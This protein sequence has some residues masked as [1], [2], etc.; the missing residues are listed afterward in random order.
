MKFKDRSN[1]ILFGGSFNPI[2]LGH[3][4]LVRAVAALPGVSGVLVVPA[5]LSPFK[6]GTEPLPAELRLRMVRAAL[7]DVA[8][9][10]VLELE[11]RRPPPSYTVDTV[12]EIARTYPGARLRLAMGCDTFLGF[13]RWH[14][15]GDILALADLLV[16][17]RA[18]TEPPFREG[19]AGWL[20][21]LPEPWA[22]GARVD[23]R[24]AVHTPEGRALVEYL[25]QPLPPCC[26]TRIRRERAYHLVPPGARELLEAHERGSIP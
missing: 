14:R 18:G 11:L 6:T 24:G 5:A 15:A 2:H 4:A 1:F 10:S 13:A 3:A 22:R 25:D 23:S 16:V 19:G 9:V 21:L 20:D 26:S 17:A 7:A 8:G 12:A